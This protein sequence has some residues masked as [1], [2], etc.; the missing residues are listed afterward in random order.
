M[1]AR[2]LT[3]VLMPAAVFQS[4]IVGGAYGT[5]R[6]V[7][8]YVSRYGPWGGLGVV[9]LAG[10]GFGVI[11]AAT[12]EFARITRCFDYRSFLRALLGRA[13]FLYELM[14]VALLLIVLAVTGAAAG[15][16]LEEA[17]HVPR[18]IGI[19]LM[20]AA[21]ALTTYFGRRLVAIT[22]TAG[23]VLLTLMI[24][25]VCGTVVTRHGAAIASAFTSAHDVAGWARSAFVFVLYNTALAPVLLYVAA[26]L[27]NRREALS[28]GFAAGTAG[29]LPALLFHVAF[30]SHYPAV[31]RAEIPTYWLIDRLGVPMLLGFYVCVLF[32]TIVQTGVGVL[33][34]VNERLDTWWRERRGVALSRVQHSVVAVAA[35]AVSMLLARLGIVDLVAHGYGSL[36]WGFLFV[37]TVPVLTLGIA[38][39]RRVRE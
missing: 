35:L 20:L 17:F 24:V 38:R 26:P 7:A 23:A 5:G 27:R 4:V 16:V 1:S 18:S 29:V 11:L 33:Q 32:M 30:M 13:W 31:T 9:A 10:I 25:L 37:Y 6:E 14:F 2:W 22:L 3:A 34:G 28:A 19:G 15:Q 36:A 39:I 21:I 8:E 12:F